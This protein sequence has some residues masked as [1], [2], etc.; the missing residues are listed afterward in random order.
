MD[1]QQTDSFLNMVTYFKALDSYLLNAC[2]SATTLYLFVRDNL[3]DI[4]CLG[5]LFGAVNAIAAFKISM[6]PAVHI[7]DLCLSTHKMLLWSLSNLL[8]FNIHNQRHPFAVLEDSRNKP[9]RPLPAR[10][11]TPKQTT[12]LMF[13]MYPVIL[14]ISYKWGGMIPCLLEAFS[15]LWYNEWGAAADPFLKNLLN[16]I[17]FACFLAGPLEVATG[18]SVFS[19]DGTAAVWLGM[20][21]ACITTTVHIQ[22]FRDVQGD[23]VAGRRTV[24]LAIGDTAARLLAAVCVFGWTGAV[25]W[26]WR[27]AWVQVVFAAVAGG[28]LLWNLFWDRTVKGDV[29]TWKLWPAWIVGLFLVPVI[30]GKF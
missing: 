18:K 23:R 14:L 2:Y 5:Y 19:G 28:I 24:P 13:A 25:A 27:A 17:G 29:F 22:D 12:R 4:V 8:L 7:T 20:L 30:P 11:I 3:K 9:W 16:G 21:S 6:G 10:R 15:C 1:T 26:Y